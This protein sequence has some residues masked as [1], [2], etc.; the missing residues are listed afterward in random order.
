MICFIIS[1]ASGSLTQEHLIDVTPSL[2][3]ASPLKGKLSSTI[4]YRDLI[5]AELQFQISGYQRKVSALLNSQS[6]KF[7]VKS[8][9]L[10]IPS[11]PETLS[12]CSSMYGYGDGLF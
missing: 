7:Y 9:T 4:E 1:I 6:S 12:Q 2:K 10:G 3:D 8:D 11:V 5:F